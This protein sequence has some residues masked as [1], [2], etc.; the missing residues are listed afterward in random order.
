MDAHVVVT[1]WKRFVVWMC[2][3][4]GLTSQIIPTVYC[5]ENATAQAVCELCE[6][7][8]KHKLYNWLVLSIVLV[9]LV[10]LLLLVGFLCHRLWPRDRS[11]L[12][13][14]VH[15]YNLEHPEQGVLSDLI[16]VS[17]SS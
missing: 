10:L 9:L 1:R 15:R 12:A 2:V 7:A 6:L 8:E 4:L 3:V 16:Q 17:S 11:A 5:A 13:R 14:V